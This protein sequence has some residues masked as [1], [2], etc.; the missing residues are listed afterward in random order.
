MSEFKS[1]ED[2]IAQLEKTVAFLI[3]HQTDAL[4]A[5]A[6]NGLEL[7][8]QINQINECLVAVVTG[9]AA[10]TEEKT[11]QSGFL[12][13]IQFGMTRHLSNL[14]QGM[15]KIQA[16]ESDLRASIPS[17]PPAAPEP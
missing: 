3:Q 8:K 1:A 9:M 5:S 15:A 14:E 16:L 7:L 17:A 13:K 12:N 2:R 11:G 6:R 10:I 4:N